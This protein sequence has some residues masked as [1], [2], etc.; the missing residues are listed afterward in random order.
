[1]SAVHGDPMPTA[2]SVKPG[3]L[4]HHWRAISRTAALERPWA[5]AT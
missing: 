3:V 4:P 1:M 2:A 5:A